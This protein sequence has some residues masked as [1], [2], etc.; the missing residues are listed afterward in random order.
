MKGKWGIPVGAAELGTRLEALAVDERAIA[1]FRACVH[2][3]QGALSRLPNEMIDAVAEALRDHAPEAGSPSLEWENMIERAEN[4]FNYLSH[5][6]QQRLQEM[7][8]SLLGPSERIWDDWRKQLLHKVRLHRRYEQ[9]ICRYEENIQTEQLAAQEWGGNIIGWA[10]ISQY[11]EEIALLQETVSCYR[12]YDREKRQKHW[13]NAEAFGAK[14]D[15]SD[16][17][18]F[19]VQT[20]MP[21]REITHTGHSLTLQPRCL[22]T[23]SN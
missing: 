7:H 17:T 23:T 18:F 20:G 14:L 2:L 6:T 22:Q 19:P 15:G 10:R 3:S 13:A 11:Q 21:P 12:V 8:I 5:F 16:R 4:R 9:D 1:A